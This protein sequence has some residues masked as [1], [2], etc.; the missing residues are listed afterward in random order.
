[1]RRILGRENG[2]LAYLVQFGCQQAGLPT[3]AHRDNQK[4]IKKVIDGKKL[5]A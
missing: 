2:R 5:V 1:M 3:P 4:K